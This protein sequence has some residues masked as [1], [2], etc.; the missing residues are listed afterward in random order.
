MA[1]ADQLVSAQAAYHDLMTGKAVRVFQDQNGER[2]EYTVAN[3]AKLANYIQELQR[4][5]SGSLPSRPMRVW[6]GW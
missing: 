4:Q 1:L 5:L 6:M 2:V 3:A